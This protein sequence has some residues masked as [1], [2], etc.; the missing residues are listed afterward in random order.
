MRPRRRRRPGRPRGPDGVDL[1]VVLLPTA[2]LAA[3]PRHEKF[4]PEIDTENLFVPSLDYV[5][6]EAFNERADVCMDFWR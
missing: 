2:R 5:P 6:G 1:L 4:G 3:E